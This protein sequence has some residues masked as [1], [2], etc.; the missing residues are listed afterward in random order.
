G[1]APREAGRRERPFHPGVGG[2]HRAPGVTLGP[3]VVERL[4]EYVGESL[5]RRRSERLTWLAA[6]TR[7]EPPR[8]HGAFAERPDREHRPHRELRLLARRR[9]A[10]VSSTGGALR[11]R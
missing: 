8:A 3:E 11:G 4:G 5:R 1:R 2:D 7:R 6:P 10:R 9:R